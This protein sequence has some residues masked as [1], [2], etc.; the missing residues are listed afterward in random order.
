MVTAKS[1]KLLE[2]LSF[3]QD[4]YEGQ[5]VVSTAW[6]YSGMVLLDHCRKLW[7]R[8]PVVSIDTGFLFDE[9]VAFADRIARK[10]MLD[11]SWEGPR[12]CH[13]LPPSKECC[14]ERKVVPMARALSP[15]QAWISALR[16]DQAT[17]RET[18][19][20]VEV[21]RFGKIR[22]APMLDWTSAECWAYIEAESVPVQPL[23]AQG[24][25]SIGCQP[26]TNLPVAGNERSGRWQGARQECGLH[27]KEGDQ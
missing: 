14:F 20:E 4:M 27:E 7:A 18:S 13:Q 23:H 16:R 25:R 12:D 17:T 26:C 8:V 1:D 10:W 24:Y 9:T 6:G 15:W 21:D 5:I 19:K 2:V 3:Y 22:L 11:V